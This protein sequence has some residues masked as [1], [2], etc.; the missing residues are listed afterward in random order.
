METVTPKPDSAM[1]TLGLCEAMAIE[2]D[3][4]NDALQKAKAQNLPLSYVMGRM[5]DINKNMRNIIYKRSGGIY[6]K[7][8]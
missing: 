5:E 3:R 7:K 1:T 6:Y 4:M 8:P 2:I